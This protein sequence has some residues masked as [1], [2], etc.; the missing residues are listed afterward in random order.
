ML[1][2]PRAPRTVTLLLVAALAPACRGCEE[3]V[4]PPPM[5]PVPG[6]AAAPGTE[7]A[8]GA[9]DALTPPPPPTPLDLSVANTANGN[10]RG[11][12]QAAMD[13][14]H[15][16]GQ[17][18]VQACL[19][20]IPPSFQLP[21]NAAR[22]SVRYDVMPDGRTADVV[23]TGEIPPESVAC[24]KGVLEALVFPRFEG[25][26]IRSAFNLTYSRQ[27]GPPAPPR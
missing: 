22:L 6:A 18:K 27:P 5:D 26:A 13:V 15:A 17:S 12:N 9:I 1:G 20:K 11:P 19:D 3:A 24:A 10:P 2:M 21:G 23:V 16:D 4:P 7:G 8:S 25:A 14:I